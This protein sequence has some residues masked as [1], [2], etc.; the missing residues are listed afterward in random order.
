MEFLR[1]P[2]RGFVGVFFC[3][4]GE[5]TLAGAKWEREF[6]VLPFIDYRRLRGTWKA[7]LRTEDSE[8]LRC[9]IMARCTK[10][11]VPWQMLKRF[12]KI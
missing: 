7:E 3:V 6:Y 2:G 11:K 12:N 1:W 8:T 10:Y 9:V 5:T 4:E